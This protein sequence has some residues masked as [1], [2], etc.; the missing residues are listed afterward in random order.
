[1]GY[2]TEF[3]GQFDFNKPLSDKMYNYLKLFNK[4]RRMKRNVP[5]AFGIEGEFY[6]F[7]GGDYEQ[8]HETNIVDY[9]KQPSTQPSLWLQ[10][11]PSEDRL[12][13]GWDYDEKFYSYTEWLVYL[14]Y[15]VLA[16][17]GYVLNGSVLWEGEDYG[18]NG[19]IFVE[20][21]RVFVKEK[22]DD[23][24][25][26]TPQNAGNYVVV[27]GKLEWV[28]GFMRPDVVLLLDEATDLALNECVK[29]LT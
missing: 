5:D 15:K 12:S 25:E 2:H 29:L 14:I 13:L 28:S 4:T 9:N 23:K 18:D 20:D 19:E 24:Y 8:A 10:W 3:R 1:M 27:N 17:N 6:V 11:T 26:V 21:N 7:G 16:P 22:Q